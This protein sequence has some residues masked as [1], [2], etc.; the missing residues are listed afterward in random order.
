MFG[1]FIFIFCFFSVSSALLLRCVLCWSCINMEKSR[2]YGFYIYNIYT[3][4]GHDFNAHE[5]KH[6]LHFFNFFYLCYSW[7][8]FFECIS[9]NVVNSHCAQMHTHIFVAIYCWFTLVKNLILLLLLWC[10]FALFFRVMLRVSIKQMNYYMDP[11]DASTLF[12]IAVANIYIY[13]CIKR[14]F[15]LFL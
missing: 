5:L 9:T 4:V 11:I 6:W 2:E 10:C 3:F 13:V 7:T 15:V 1:R 14:F 12:T 8:D